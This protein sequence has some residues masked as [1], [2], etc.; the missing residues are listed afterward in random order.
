MIHKS[1]F[2]SV[3]SFVGV[4][5]LS[6]CTSPFP[7]QSEE[8]ETAPEGLTVLDKAAL[9]LS[10]GPVSFE[11]QVKPILESKCFACH[12][13]AAAMAGFRVESRSFAM[14]RGASFQRLVPGKPESSRFLALAGTHQ[15]VASMPPVGNRLTA[16]E[17]KI[18]WRWVAEG[19]QWPQGKAGQLHRSTA[20][21]YPE[22]AAD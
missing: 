6:D 22:K 8:S 3:I 7:K 10:D 2:V 1:I 15:N 14:T 13:G 11:R 20:R 12:S 9:S 4:M 17:S 18:L 21:L 19:A 5:T 16:T